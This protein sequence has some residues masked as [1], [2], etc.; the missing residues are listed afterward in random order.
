MGYA[1]KIQPLKNIVPVAGQRVD[2]KLQN[3]VRTHAV[4]L[5]AQA[6]VDVTTDALALLNRGSVWALFDEVGLYIDGEDRVLM[7]PRAA[8]AW[9]EVNAIS[10]LPRTRTTSL[11]A[12]DPA[13]TV[14]ESLLIP[15]AN[16]RIAKPEETAFLERNTREE[17]TAFV[18]YNGLGT[19]VYRGGVVAV[20]APLVRVTQIYDPF[21][22]EL[23]LLRPSIRQQTS[24][25][26]SAND[27]HEIFLKGSKYIGGI[28][29]QQDSDVGEVADIIN[30]IAIRG[31]DGRDLVTQ[32][33]TWSEAVQT[34]AYEYGG[35][36]AGTE[37]YLGIN[38]TR[39]GRLSQLVHPYAYA[40]L[41]LEL[42]VQP[43]VTTGAT[44]S[45]IR[46]TIFEYD[47]DTELTTAELPFV[48]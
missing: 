13:V 8:R 1:E 15:L 42:N 40:N 7:D 21:R 44:N 30:T 34:S 35:D 6:L 48:I 37:A 19:R 46:V 24:A 29:V 22:Q 33:R 5:T 20:S 4:L 41:R 45:K 14:R 18:K 32:P 16:Q 47:R 36:V 38:F 26:P 17:M 43:S 31:D 28:L 25:V 23:P 39:N 10:S 12:V 2:A 27:R 9:N 11:L 3:S